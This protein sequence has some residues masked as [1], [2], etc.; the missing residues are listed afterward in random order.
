MR[1]AREA[2]RE[3]AG[4]PLR[5][6]PVRTPR[7]SGDQGSTPMPSA[8]QAGS[9]SRS[10]PRSSSEYSTWAATIGARPGK[11]AC[12]VGGPRGLPAGEVGHPDVAD[13][14]A[15]HGV[16][17]RR[18][19]LLERGVGVVAVH[20]PQVDV[21]GAEAAQRRVQGA[22]QVAAGAVAAAAG[23][24]AAARPW[25]RCTHLVA[26][27]PGGRAGSPITASASP[28]PYTSAVSIRVPPA[29]RKN[30]S[31]AAASSGSVS[32]PQVMVP[33]A[34]RETASPLRPSGRCCMGEP[35]SAEAC[36]DILVSGQWTCRPVGTG[37]GGRYSLRPQ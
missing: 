24:G 5:Y 17:E 32:R 15:V 1:S 14:A 7:P 29:S 26:G 10:M 25:W 31:W 12:Q 28:S 33:S 22:Q 13:L 37:A 21:V 4:R 35:Y 18:Q 30:L 8:A 6:L 19:G 27:R 34:S 20:L 2:A 3:S 23:A 36:S 16:V 9:T 11:A